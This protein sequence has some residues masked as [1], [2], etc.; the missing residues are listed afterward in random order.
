M[1]VIVKTVPEVQN[2]TSIDSIIAF[3][4]YSRVV[5]MD[6]HDN[7]LIKEGLGNL[8]FSLQKRE[9]ELVVFENSNIYFFN[10]ITGE[11]SFFQKGGQKYLVKDRVVL[12]FQREAIGGPGIFTLYDLEIGRSIWSSKVNFGPMFVS[13]ES[14]FFLY[15]DRKNRRNLHCNS[16]L[17]GKEKWKVDLG[18]VLERIYTS[19]EEQFEIIRKPVLH[20][21][22]LIVHLQ[23]SHS[24]WRYLAGMDIHTGKLKWHKRDYS[25]FELYNGKLYN[26]EFY[27]L[28]RVLDPETGEVEREEDLK[29]E[30]K[31]MDINCEHRFNVTDTHLY[32]KHAIKGKFGILNLNTLKVEEAHQLPDGN[33]M[34]TEEYP[35]PVDDRLYIRSAPQ[36][37]LFIYQR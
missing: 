19:E 25:N 21:E 28:F 20:K 26:L 11:E 33:T 9:R 13:V 14:H 27:G 8:R 32:F 30:F 34:S 1:Y 6:N 23:K 18:S 29:P 3:S 16:I 24:G 7:V 31:R 2:L 4:S 35:I 17:D 36:N 10:A 37:N 22:S 15:V 5:L 12:I